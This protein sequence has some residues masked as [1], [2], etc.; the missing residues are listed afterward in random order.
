ME[1]LNQPFYI[2]AKFTHCIIGE[3]DSLLVEYRESGGR[4]RNPTISL[5]N[6]FKIAVIYLAGTG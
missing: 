3:I 4:V 1:G 6:F 5:N 2:F